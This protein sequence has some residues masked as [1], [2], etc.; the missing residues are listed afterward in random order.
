MS[1]G[2]KDIFLFIVGLLGAFQFRM[3]GTFYGVEI[4]AFLSYLFIPWR[5]YTSNPMM[6]KF[7]KMSFVWLLGSIIADLANGIEMEPA[8]KGIFNIVF[9]ILQIPFVYWA[10]YDKVSRW[11]Y[12]YTGYAISTIINFYTYRVDIIN[13][14]DFLVWQFYAWVQLVVAIAAILY[15][16]KH[17]FLAYLLAVGFGVYGLFNSSRNLF[18]ILT[19]ATII[20]FFM[21]RMKG[22]D[23]ATKISSYQRKSFG[24]ILMLA[25]GA[26]AVSDSYEYLASNEIL[27]EAAYNKYE[28]QKSSKIGLASGRGD[29]VLGVEFLVRNPIIGYGSF[30]EDKEGLNPHLIRKYG[31]DYFGNN[32]NTDYFDVVPCHSVLVG[33]WNWH[34]ILAGIFWLYYLLL[35]YKSL[36][37]GVFLLEPKMAGLAVFAS[38]MM[39]WD[40]FFSP[41]GARPPFVFYFIF[42][43]L[44][45]TRY[46][47]L[48][49]Q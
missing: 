13:E 3:V 14:G 40:I 24:L 34:G 48:F 12:F 9:F 30:A 2:R 1:Q 15:Y 31:M 35:M 37:K 20:L 23:I 43:I 44:I 5:R 29:F 28:M 46:K 47:Q 6:K 33:Q 18:L 45:N 39:L 19:L 4:V 26:F 25:I 36:R 21:D 16:R 41:M 32:S 49:N 8:M 10:L 7:I 11:I 38:I 42:L 17:H 22:E 27:G